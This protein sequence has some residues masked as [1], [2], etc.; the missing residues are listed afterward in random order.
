MCLYPRLIDN[1]KY[2]ATK[3]NGGII[4]AVR[5][6]RI[7]LVPIG[8][9]NC[10]ECRRQKSTQWRTR[11][12]EDIKTN[13]NAKFITLTF[14]NESILELI[15]NY[16]EL[17]KAEG[18]A[19]DNAIA[20]KAVRLW[21]ERWRKKHKKSLRHWLVTELGHNGTENIHLHGIVWTNESIEEIRTSWQYGYIWPRKDTTK[22]TYVNEKTI[23]YIVKYITKIDTKHKTYKS[24]VL[25]SPGIGS[26]YINT[27]NA[28]KNKFME[29]L[30]K[31]TYKSRSGR[32]YNLPIYYRNKLYTEEQREKLWLHTLNKN[33]R[34]IMGEK[35]KADDIESYF[36]LIR[37]YREIN[38]KM[39]YG[40]D[41][42]DWNR[43]QYERTQR[44]I[45]T[46]TR[47]INAKNKQNASN[48]NN[49]NNNNNNK[50]NNKYKKI[51]KILKEMNI[52]IE[53][54][55]II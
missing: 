20:T 47:L 44:I 9:G 25:T 50:N 6:E 21:L 34:Y 55:K 38:T 45:N 1:P 4:P 29:E 33:E 37:H 2:K 52:N 10:I 15:T 28:T 24:I 11:L 27:L 5:D 14:S 23:N 3:K 26:N 17:Q 19:L 42:K 22:Q 41:E 54:I 51:Q 36:K 40:N 39:G 43:E 16:S 7:K 46:K 30:T 12:M 31:T 32:E 13:T 35:I 8:C 49:N 53:N 48:T 18:Y